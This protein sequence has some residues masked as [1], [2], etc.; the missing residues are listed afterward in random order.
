MM[1]RVAREYFE[2]MGKPLAHERFSPGG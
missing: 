2:A 1:L